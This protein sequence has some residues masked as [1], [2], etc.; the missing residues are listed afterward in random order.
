MLA[1]LTLIIIHISRACFMSSQAE[2]F[3]YIFC[4]LIPHFYW[5]GNFPR[6]SLS[7]TCFLALSIGMFRCLE[8]VC[9][10]LDTRLLLV[11]NSKALLFFFKLFKIFENVQ[12]KIKKPK[13]RTGKDVIFGS[14]RVMSPSNRALYIISVGWVSSL[15]LGDVLV[16]LILFPPTG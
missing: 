12:K 4:N 3:F 9:F 16:S 10:P 2:P 8:L 13:S 5:E 11:C 14:S 6:V 15:T 1:S 7:Y